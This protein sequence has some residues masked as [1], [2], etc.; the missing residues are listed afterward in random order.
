[1]GFSA[2]SGT[3]KVRGTPE[4]AQARPE[5]TAATAEVRA[6]RFGTIWPLGQLGGDEDE[7]LNYSGETVS[8]A[9]V[10]GRGDREL[11]HVQFASGYGLVGLLAD[12]LYG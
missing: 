5:S 4:P 10:R 2:S 3:T 12:L 8:L 1:M 7:D 9:P 11:L 6:E